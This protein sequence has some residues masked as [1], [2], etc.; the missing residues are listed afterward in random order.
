[1]SPAAVHLDSICLDSIYLN[2]IYLDPFH[3]GFLVKR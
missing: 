3:P 2:P 1:M